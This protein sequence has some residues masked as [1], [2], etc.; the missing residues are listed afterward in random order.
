MRTP[1]PK[2]RSFASKNWAMAVGPK[3]ALASTRNS[4]SEIRKP[5]PPVR[6]PP[7]RPER[8]GSSKSAAKKGQMA[9]PCVAGAGRGSHSAHHAQ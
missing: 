3:C 7:T 8:L 6:V 5:I 2:K 4:R 1:S 9:S